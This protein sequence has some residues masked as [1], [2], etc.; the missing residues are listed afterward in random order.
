MDSHPLPADTP[1]D[2]A[3][4]AESGP[5]LL[6]EDRG[7]IAVLTLNRPKARNSLSEALLK[8]LGGAIDAIAA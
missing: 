3:G 1:S 6:R 8:A 7:K 5:I 2:A 4:N